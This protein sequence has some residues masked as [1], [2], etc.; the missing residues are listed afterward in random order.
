MQLQGSK[1]E[2]GMCGQR[3]VIWEMDFEVK[4]TGFAL[5]RGRGKTEG[6]P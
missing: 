1:P 4:A 5:G 3:E 6:K 2:L